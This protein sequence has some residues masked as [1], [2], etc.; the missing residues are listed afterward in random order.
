M[1]Y[2]IWYSTT[3]QKPAGHYDLQW[4]MGYTP[5]LPTAWF[6]NPKCFYGWAIRATQRQP[7]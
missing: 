5:G 7:G 6:S 3:Y 4:Y 2:Q 1:T